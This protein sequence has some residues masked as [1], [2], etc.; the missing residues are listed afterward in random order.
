ML[1]TDKL[2]IMDCGRIAQQSRFDPLFSVPSSKVVAEFLGQS[3]YLGAD[4]LT[5][6]EYHTAYGCAELFVAHRR[7]K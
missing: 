2:V 4:V 5:A 1:V 6:A 7:V 3:I